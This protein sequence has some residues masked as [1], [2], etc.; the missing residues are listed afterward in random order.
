MPCACD[1]VP[2]LDVDCVVEAVI[3]SL[4]V[5][6]SGALF[7]PSRAPTRALCPT[8]MNSLANV[9]SDILMIKQQ[10]IHILLRNRSSVM[11]EL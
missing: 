11:S 6:G 8:H 3:A 5:V 4:Q 9:N 1:V 7:H 10:L 2:L